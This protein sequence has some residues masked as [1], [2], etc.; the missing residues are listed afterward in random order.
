[1]LSV[2]VKNVSGS[3][4]KF[5]KKLEQEQ[6]EKD[7]FGDREQTGKFLFLTWQSIKQYHAAEGSP[8][9]QHHHQLNIRSLMIWILKSG[10]NDQTQFLPK[11][12]IT[13]ATSSED[14]R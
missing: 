7:Q 1:M 8:L 14:I 11:R 2:L 3:L 13:L 6:P 9:S 5:G 4:E 12:E 10:Q